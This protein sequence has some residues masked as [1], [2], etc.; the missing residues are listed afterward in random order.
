MSFVIYM[1]MSRQWRII[2]M[3]L[4]T[5]A[6]RVGS[7]DPGMLV[8]RRTLQ[9]ECNRKPKDRQM[10]SDSD[11]DSYLSRDR[12]RNRNM[13]GGRGRET[14]AKSWHI[15]QESAPKVRVG[16]CARR[17]KWRIKSCLIRWLL[18]WFRTKDNYSKSSIHSHKWYKSV[19]PFMMLILLE[20][21]PSWSFWLA[22]LTYYTFLWRAPHHPRQKLVLPVADSIPLLFWPSRHNTA[23][24]SGYSQVT[25]LPVP[26]RCVVHVFVSLGV[27]MCA[28]QDMF[29]CRY[30][31]VCPCMFHCE[32]RCT[33]CIQKYAG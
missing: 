14:Q 8:F 28:Y 1:N 26:V 7:T 18:P 20:S 9:R 32:Y 15:K 27:Y 21:Q 6:V 13:G 4:V 30:M 3:I 17:E 23:Q 5:S 22:G 16:G 25:V 11:K 2:R 12:D 10:D 31:Y 19:L 24:G 29:V 33:L